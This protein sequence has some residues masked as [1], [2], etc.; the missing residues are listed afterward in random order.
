MVVPLKSS[1]KLGTLFDTG[2]TYGEA[3]TNVNDLNVIFSSFTINYTG[4]T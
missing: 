4:T 3:I 1:V 2:S